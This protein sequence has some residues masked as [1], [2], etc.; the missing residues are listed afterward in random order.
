M[1]INELYICTS[2]MFPAPERDQSRLVIVRE[3]DQSNVTFSVCSDEQPSLDYNVV[4][5]YTSAFTID[6]KHFEEL[7][8][9]VGN[10]TPAMLGGLS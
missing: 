8:Q 7:F 9:P 3:Y 6:K 5:F 4:R 2:P 1:K 10:A